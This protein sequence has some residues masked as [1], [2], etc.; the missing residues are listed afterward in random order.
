[1]KNKKISISTI[2]K[3]CNVG[4]GTVSRYFNN[5]YVSDQK[6]ELIKKVVE[7]YNFSPNFA[8]HSIKR[9]IQEVYFLIPDLTKSNTFVI[10][11][12][13]KY[14]QLEFSETMVFVIQTTYNQE[15]YLKYLKKVV[16]R[17]PAA[18]VLF[19]ISDDLK[20]KD[21]LKKITIPFI[22]YGKD[23]GKFYFINNDQEMMI[24]LLETMNNQN[25][26]NHQKQI[27]YIGEKPE[28]N[29]STGYDRFYSLNN[30]F[31]NK[32]IKFDYLFFEH[33]SE[34][35]IYNLIKELNL[36][37]KI[38]ICGTHTCHKILLKYI[39]NQKFKNITLTDIYQK[40]SLLLPIFEKQYCIAI[41]YQNL[42][43]RINES[44]NKILNNKPI[45]EQN[46]KYLNYEIK[47]LDR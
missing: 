39:V 35:S 16:A 15:T 31:K 19:A 5:G 46:E 26:F 9:K 17:K 40:N 2:A 36:N 13:L 28:T 41:D 14:L 37:N 4:V 21:Y 32:N 20:I 45:D 38:I 43:Q 34:T 11:K 33:N 47:V 24:S 25:E 44:I 29:K 8:A 22:S 6:K 7:K 23:W 1:M 30:W 12:I 27:L 42:V 10:K 3:E 18:L